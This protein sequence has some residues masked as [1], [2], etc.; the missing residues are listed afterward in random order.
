MAFQ[1]LG[2]DGQVAIGRAADLQAVR[3]TAALGVDVETE[4]PFGIFRSEVDLSLRCVDALGG[5]N[6]MV[7]QLLHRHQ[8]ALLVRKNTLGIRDVHWT[9]RH[10]VEHL[11]A[12]LD[13]LP[14]LLHTDLVASVAI[15]FLGD[16]HIEIVFLVTEIRAAFAQ[17]AIDPRGAQVRTRHAVG[18]GGLL[19]DRAD[20][21]HPVA[22]DLVVVEQL[23]DL[24]D[25]HLA[26]FEETPHRCVKALRHIAELA[27]DTGVGGGK[28]RT[29]EQ[30]AEIVDLFPLGE[31]VEENSHRADVHRAN[32]H[33]EHVRG[34][35]G[36]LAA[37]HAQ[38]LAA[39]RKFPAHQFL[40]RAGI[41]DV[42][43]QRRKVVEPVR[44]G[45][46]LVVV[47]V[48]GDLLVAA[49]K[50]AHIGFGG[51]DYLTVQLK[52]QA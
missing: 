39:R 49:V 32:P 35:A 17:V 21:H 24:A 6:E 27:A 14:H 1:Q 34:D 9:S 50:E 44:V 11:P 8:R 3:N 37:E 41:G 26:L 15:T 33:P 36:K 2:N 38:R 29:S 16:R 13:R 51:M 23:G 47:H 28:T 43:R 30:L 22:E 48:L 7:D 42:V 12:D 4:L 45:Y 10:S 31:G 46:E 25:G 52:D 40:H 5:D 18:N 20:V 19:R